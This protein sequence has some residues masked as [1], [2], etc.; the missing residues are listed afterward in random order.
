MSHIY[1]YTLA[2]GQ[3]LHFVFPPYTFRFTIDKGRGGQSIDRNGQHR[4]SIDHNGQHRRR[5]QASADVQKTSIN[6]PTMEAVES[7]TRGSPALG[8]K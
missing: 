3:L 4:K 5:Y 1:I 7:N 2:L 8:E 6:S